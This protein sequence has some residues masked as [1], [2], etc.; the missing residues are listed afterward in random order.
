M[1]WLFFVFLLANLLVFGLTSLGGGN[2]TVDPRS[3]EINAS[4]VRIVTGQ[5][6]T[7]KKASTASD[8]ASAI[9]AEAS[10]VAASQVQAASAPALA[11]TVA[12][13]SQAV[14]LVCLRWSGFSVEQASLVRSRLKNMG[15]TA[16]ESGGTDGAK[17]WVYIP[18]LDSA[19]AARKKTQQIIELG[20]EDYFVVNNGSKWQNAISLG[21]FSTRE[22][23]E[24]RLTELKNKGVRSA[25]VRDKDD[26][27]KP[28]TFLLKGVAEADMPKLDKLGGTFRGVELRE[29]ACR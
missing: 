24:R 27:F 18:P 1:K 11:S 20:V 26:T 10:A 22:A 7:L 29:T 3:R 4:Q 9:A 17:I 19:D 14:R 15:L 6:A 2:N 5:L 16:T 8:I 23:A 25:V 28:V 21:V 13:A 12:A